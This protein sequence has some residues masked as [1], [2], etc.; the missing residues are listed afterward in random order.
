[1]SNE[2]MKI[3]KSSPLFQ[4]KNGDINI[5]QFDKIADKFKEYAKLN[6]IIF[7]ESEED[8]YKKLC[9]ACIETENKYLILEENNNIHYLILTDEAK[10]KTNNGKDINIDNYKKYLDLD[11]ENANDQIY[12]SWKN[13]FDGH[14]N[15]Q[16]YYD[17]KDLGLYD[18]QGNWNFY[19][20]K[21]DLK[22]LGYE[23]LENEDEEEDCL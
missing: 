12:T 5:G 22:T 15:D 18:E 4:F 19:I 7:K 13:L 21:E 16:I 9:L 11:F 6:R 14:I 20:E 8:F 17:I 23:N 3:G 2:N 1:M 10:E